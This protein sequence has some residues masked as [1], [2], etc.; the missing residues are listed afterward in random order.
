L[1]KTKITVE[2]N[3]RLLAMLNGRA[4]EQMDSH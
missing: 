1:P 2:Q 4:D 3:D